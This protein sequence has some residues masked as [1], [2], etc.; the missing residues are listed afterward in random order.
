MFIPKKDILYFSIAS[1][2]IFVIC[3]VCELFISIREL[4]NEL[5][6]LEKKVITPLVKDIKNDFTLLLYQTQYHIKTNKNNLTSFKFNNSLELIDNFQCSPYNHNIT[7]SFKKED[8][9]GN[10]SNIEWYFKL[11]NKSY[12]CKIDY[13]SLR[14]V[15]EKRISFVGIENIYLYIENFNLPDNSLEITKLE[16][17]SFYQSL[18][19]KQLKLL[20]SSKLFYGYTKSYISSQYKLIIKLVL[21]KTGILVLLTILIYILFR[22]YIFRKIYVKLTKKIKEQ[23]KKYSILDKNYQLFFEENNLLKRE[24]KLVRIFTLE[25]INKCHEIINS[26]NSVV[27]HLKNNKSISSYEQN[28]LI[29]QI[30][31]LTAQKKNSGLILLKNNNPNLVKIDSII[32]TGLDLVEMEIK[33]K[34]INLKWTPSG[35]ELETNIDIFSL[36]QIIFSIIKIAVHRLLIHESILIDVTKDGKFFIT[37]EDNSINREYSQLEDLYKKDTIFLGY[38]ELKD[39]VRFYNIKLIESKKYSKNIIKL[40]FEKE[41][42][43]SFGEEFK[44]SNSDNILNITNYVKKK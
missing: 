9:F 43:E 24:I 27:I 6:R 37:I 18:W 3:E 23:Q 38:S 4:K 14:K 8:I 42:S 20:D 29:N 30:L 22:K 15:I 19:S 31:N 32:Q 25:Y 40:L 12:I 17:Q 1:I 39:L 2:T 36:K 35:S 28:W 44:E 5:S 11:L 34:K 41:Y 26:I 7:N 10:I 33:N 13:T 21:L 16:N